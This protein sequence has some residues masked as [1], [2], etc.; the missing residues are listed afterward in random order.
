[1][2]PL[3]LIFTLL[4]LGSAYNYCNNDTDFCK[5]EGTV[6]FM[7]RMKEELVSCNIDVSF[8]CKHK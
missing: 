7:C 5:Q 4:P 8:F 1:M 6:H 3:V 2:I